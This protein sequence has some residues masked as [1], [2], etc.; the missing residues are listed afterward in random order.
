MVRSSFVT[1]NLHKVWAKKYVELD[2]FFGLL[3]VLSNSG[4]QIK[5]IVIPS[6][7]TAVPFKI[8]A[9]YFKESGEYTRSDF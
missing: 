7:L 1:P 3:K 2:S 5:D 4:V 6:L 9:S 8:R